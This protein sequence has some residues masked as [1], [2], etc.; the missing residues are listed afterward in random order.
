MNSSNYRIIL[1]V[2]LGLSDSV[3]RSTNSSRISL[4]LAQ[5]GEGARQHYRSVAA[6]LTEKLDKGNLQAVNSHAV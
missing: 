3:Q 4:M 1:S 6:S 5:A 2:Y